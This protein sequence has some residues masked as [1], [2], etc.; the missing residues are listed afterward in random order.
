MK[1]EKK[2]EEAPIKKEE[3]I[4]KPVK[5]QVNNSNVEEMFGNSKNFYSAFSPRK[6]TKPENRESN[7]SSNN[8][9]PQEIRRD[10]SNSLVIP[11]NNQKGNNYQ[12]RSTTASKNN[13]NNLPSLKLPNNNNNNFNN[14][15]VSVDSLTARPSTQTR[16][17]DIS[18][19]SE[20]IKEKLPKIA[21]FSVQSSNF[22]PSSSDNVVGNIVTPRD[23]FGTRRKF[24]EMFGDST[25]QFANHVS[26]SSSQDD[27]SNN[28]SGN[29][30]SPRDVVSPRDG[31][32][33]SWMEKV[34]FKKAINEQKLQG[35]DIIKS[36]RSQE[37]EN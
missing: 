4:K 31:T 33:P 37:N 11:K 3:I 13:Q 26:D 2:I 34:K 5:K 23:V 9:N 12:D 20:D 22:T 21:N 7:N 10:R 15:K 17:I 14:R 35:G 36:P 18:N 29:K 1:E 24:F 19:L 8:N 32:A 27:P 6:E 30:I 25:N 28:E 16:D